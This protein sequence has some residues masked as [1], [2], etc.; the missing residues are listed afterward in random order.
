MPG[1]DAAGADSIIQVDAPAQL[2]SEF[3]VGR[4]A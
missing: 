2:F 3:H 4:L 1:N